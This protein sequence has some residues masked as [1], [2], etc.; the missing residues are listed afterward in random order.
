MAQK[1]QI[2][3]Q[4]PGNSGPTISP[5]TGTAGKAA[6]F[7]PKDYAWDGFGWGKHLGEGV[8]QGWDYHRFTQELGSEAYKDLDPRTRAEVIAMARKDPAAAGEYLAKYR[9]R[10]ERYAAD[11]SY[12]DRALELDRE[13]TKIAGRNAATA[14]ERLDLDIDKNI[15]AERRYREYDEKLQ[16]RRIAG[17]ERIEADPDTS[18]LAD[19]FSVVDPESAGKLYVGRKEQIR[20]A[21]A[22]QDIQAAAEGGAR[23]IHYLTDVR[24]YSQQ[25]AERAAAALAPPPGYDASTQGPYE[26]TSE[27]FRAA[28]SALAGEADRVKEFNKREGAYFQ[29]VKE[30]KATGLKSQRLVGEFVDFIVKGDP[31]LLPTGKFD[32]SELGKFAQWAAGG[33]G[34]VTKAQA[35]VFMAMLRGPLLDNLPPG[36]ASDKDVEIAMEPLTA[37]I[38][39]GS[40]EAFLSA[41]AVLQRTLAIKSGLEPE[42]YAQFSVGRALEKFYPGKY[43]AAGVDAAAQAEAVRIVSEGARR[44]EG[45]P[46]VG[47]Y[48][49]EGEKRGATPRETAPAAPADVPAGVNPESGEW[50]APGIDES[51]NIGISKGRI[52]VDGH[53]LNLGLIRGILSDE[54]PVPP[55]VKLQVEQYAQALRAT[56]KRNSEP[57]PRRG[58][59]RVR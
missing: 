56:R 8:R 12:R 4:L 31:N 54:V 23:G 51:H 49:E 55:S 32:Q 11:D 45:A 1:T 59:R 20:G 19:V 53:P 52:S 28:A 6:V 44:R 17:L 58:G 24:G 46:I 26:P 15:E 35:R 37:A 42:D 9:E 29:G 13:R 43:K 25:T 21:R 27:Q 39:A 3:Y 48:P 14:E 34:E 33:G 41:L 5:G 50:E 18:D 47:F 30:L 7:S 10:T 16:K 2:F 22:D 40:P 57:Q 36:A 38:E